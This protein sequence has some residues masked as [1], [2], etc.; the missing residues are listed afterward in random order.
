MLLNMPST[1]APRQAAKIRTLL[2]V[3]MQHTSNITSSTWLRQQQQL[4]N[5]PHQALPRALLLLHLRVKHLRRRLQVLVGIM[6]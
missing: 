6:L 4:N 5:L 3:A 1:M 2:T